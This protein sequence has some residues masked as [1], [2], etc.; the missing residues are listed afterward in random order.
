[1]HPEQVAEIVKRHP[2]VIKARLV[3][4]GKVSAEV[5]TLK[6]EVSGASADL[7]E[8]IMASARELTKIRVEVVMGA[9]GSLVNDG[10]VIEDARSY[11]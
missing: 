7:A 6:L 8:R 4:T 3:V 9:A 10:K 1:V 2:E 5:V 11:E